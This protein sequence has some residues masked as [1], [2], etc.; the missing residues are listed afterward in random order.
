MTRWLYS[1]LIRLHPACFR[2]RFGEQML[3][4]FDESVRQRGGTHLL[5][6]A[7]V[8][9]FRQRLFRPEPQAFARHMNLAWI[10]SII[11]IEI[12][13]VMEVNPTTTTVGASLL[14]ALLPIFTF[15]SFHPLLSRGL[16]GDDDRFISI[17]DANR[18][19][20]T[21]LERQRDIFRVWAEHTGRILML[22][23]AIWGVPVLIGA[24]FGST[25]VTRSWAFVNVIVVGIQTLTYFAVLKSV[26]KRSVDALQQQ[27]EAH[28]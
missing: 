5:A 4:V 13:V 12:L 20:Q 21:K 15:L 22:C 3:S 24:L 1:F 19:R 17:S 2:Q 8:S 14:Y 11:P 23:L 9:L 7:A 10:L 28:R 25:H 18:Q 27:I 16:S 6:D 26:D